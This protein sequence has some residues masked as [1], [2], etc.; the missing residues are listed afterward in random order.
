MEFLDKFVIPQSLEHIN[1]LHYLATLVLYIFIPF[2]SIVF[3][4]TLL[5]LVY[6][7]KAHK[8]SDSRLNTLSNDLISMFTVNKN[9]GII[10]GIVPLFTL[11][12]IYAQLLNSAE[13]NSIS[14]LF[15]ASLLM[16][17]ALIFIYTYR[18]SVSFNLIFNSIKDFKT[19][20]SQV[21]NE[22]K[23][24]DK[25]TKKLSLNT[26]H[27]GLILL[28][29]SVWFYLAG[30]NLALYTELSVTHSLLE[31]L[32]SINVLSRLLF[33]VTFAMGITGSAILFRFFFWEG[34][35]KNLDK[36]YK[37]LVKTVAIK[38]SFYFL[39]LVPLFLIIYLATLPKTSL[40]TSVFVYSGLVIFG[41]FV[42]YN[43]LYSLTKEEKVSSN[44]LLFF[45]L[46]LTMCFSLTKDQLVMNNSNVLHSLKLNEK[47]DALYASLTGGTKVVEVS[48][49]D[50]FKV[51]CTPCHAFDYKI[52]GPPY[53]ETMPKYEGKINDLVSFILN[54]KKVNP[55]YPP[56]PNPG[57]KPN[58][59]KAVA[60]YILD[61]FKK[62]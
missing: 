1:L 49:A 54:P 19:K 4:S 12:I 48:G 56:M 18:Y 47:Y 29:L 20:D 5:S 62:K 52:V 24:L 27:Y 50:V 32:F 40:S 58:E 45:V 59:A 60:K 41:L 17:V 11:T 55:E 2:I 23:K 30:L 7:R 37:I 8:T 38:T 57:L 46:I 53:N 61:E 35:V 34:G 28:T 33:F 25:T 39:A 21:N 43:V 51:R 42:C 26:G 16:I 14:Y 15:I 22:I 3:G 13:N 44:G 6:K 9:V 10:L 31:A 36:E